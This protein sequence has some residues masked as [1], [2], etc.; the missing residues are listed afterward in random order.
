MEGPGTGELGFGYE[1]RA[2]QAWLDPEPIRGKG[3]SER[4]V[5]P[6]AY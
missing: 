2:V 3:L 1:P 5:D 4:R 6:H